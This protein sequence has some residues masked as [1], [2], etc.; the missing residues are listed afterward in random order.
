MEPAKLDSSFI[1]ENA[2]QQ[3]AAML[4]SVGTLLLPIKQ[5]ATAQ[6]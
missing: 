2:N 3:L 6:G 1:D 4:A 5:E